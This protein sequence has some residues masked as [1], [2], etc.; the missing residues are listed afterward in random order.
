MPPAK[1]LFTPA[2]DAARNLWYWPD[3][4]AMTASAF[5]PGA[6]MRHCPSWSMPTPSPSRP[7]ACR[8]GGVTRLDLP[9]RHLE[10]AITWYGLALTLIGVYFAFAAS[11][12]RRVVSEPSVAVQSVTFPQAA[13]ASTALVR[14]HLGLRLSLVSPSLAS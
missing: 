4:A 11:R 13:A 5:P 1:A 3:V 10:Y 7:A 9:N 14:V 2:N 8:R 6:V 12:L